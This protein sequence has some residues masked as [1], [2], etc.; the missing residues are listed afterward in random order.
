MPIKFTEDQWNVFELLLSKQEVLSIREIVAQTGV[1]Q[2]LAASTLNH[3]RDQGW[4]TIEEKEREELVPAEDALEQVDKGLPER[5]ALALI[6]KDGK[7]KI[8][9]RD[10]VGDLKSKGIQ[11][12]EVIKWGT[13]RGWL[14]KEKDEIVILKAGQGALQNPGDDEKAIR[15]TIEI[16]P[17]TRT[18]FLDE[19]AS[20]SID[21]NN[22]KQLLKNRGTLA[23]IKPRMFRFV[24]LT[25]SGRETLGRKTG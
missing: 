6:S 20:H 14:D 5:Q 22:V 13:A 1:D 8:K 11:L 21:G 3:A 16:N 4:L 23:K 12:N 19:L 2:A 18:I 9:I 25:P 10:L 24:E 17:Q 7:S 15:L